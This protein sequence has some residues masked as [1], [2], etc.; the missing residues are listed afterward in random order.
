MEPIPLE[1]YERA[2]AEFRRFDTGGNFLFP[3]RDTTI[4]LLVSAL[5][6]LIFWKWWILIITGLLLLDLTRKEGIREGYVHG[7]EFGM[8]RGRSKTNIHLSE[9]VPDPN[10]GHL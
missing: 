10:N 5:S 4:A 6:F 8:E 1:E 9:T 7:F 3:I 2:R